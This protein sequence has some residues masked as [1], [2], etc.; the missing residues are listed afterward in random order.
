MSAALL[1]PPPRRIAVFR[2]L[3]LG[4]MLCATPA[5]RAL[6]HGL[7]E[8]HITL[9]GLPWA[10]EFA[11]RLAS[12]DA[13]IE[14]PGFPGLPE[15]EC[16]AERLPAFLAE[17]Q[18]GRFDLV[19]QMHGSGTLT[20]PLVATF[21]G[22]RMAGF[23]N[24]HSAYPPKDKALFCDWPE[25]GHEIDRLLCLTDHLGFP[26]HGRRLDFPLT[27]DDRRRCAGLW[28]GVVSSRYVCVHAG[29]QLPSRRWN[30]DR[31]ADVAD[32]LAADGRE[33]VLTGSDKEEHLCAE[34]AERMRHRSVNLAG[35]TDLW[36]L[37]ALLERADCVVCNDTGVSHVAA[38][39]ATPSVVVSCGSD[40]D[41]WAPLERGLHQVF[42]RPMPCRPCQHLHCPE[43]DGC[44]SGVDPSEV[45]EAARRV[46]RGSS[47]PVPETPSAESSRPL[48][49]HA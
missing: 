38:A 32:Q 23:R 13:F 26:R 41:R 39:V 35:R 45:A 28:P 15:S 8:A 30:V 21:G 12:V 47:A 36:T 9:I 18:A 4:D 22:V 1:S 40:V 7:P 34:L 48:E 43:I 46:A 24:A 16:A 6:R 37:G 5:L 14:F 33:V 11:L 2:A 29:A 31:F 44:A 20:N 25:S 10:R 42:W 27:D 49:A 19:I 3:M 17:V